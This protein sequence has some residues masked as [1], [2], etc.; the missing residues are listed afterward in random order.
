MSDIDLNK[1]RRFDGGL[2]LVFHEL[3]RLRRASAVAERLGLSQPAISHALARL[4]DLFE[5]QLFIRRPH[6]FEPT[7]RAL[8]LAPKI[9]ALIALTGEALTPDARF[10]PATSRRLFALAAPEF[11]TALIGAD[12]INRLRETAPTVAFAV[13]HASE[14]EAYKALR[15]GECDVALGRFGAPR[16]GFQ[17]EPLFED[18][19]AVIAR[20]GHPTVS[21]QVDEASWRRAGHVFA[22]S[23]SE[24]AETLP[25]GGRRSIPGMTMLAA[26]PHWLTVMMLVSATDGIGTVPRKLAERHADRLG[27]QVI[28][29][30]FPNPDTIRV[31]AVRR[32]GVADA[33]LDWFLEQVR[34]AA[35]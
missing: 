6:G 18:I 14:E 13:G 32:A 33:G 20:R 26:V 28:P 15:R 24:T 10:D 7:Q 5:D 25:P 35:A 1:V 22:W 30:P 9:E 27:L 16:P 12:L 34:A 23:P 19:Y 11:V 31:S 29:I 3:L 2:L 17:V 21:G 8:E 4:R